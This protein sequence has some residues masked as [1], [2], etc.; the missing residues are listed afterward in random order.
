M[1]TQECICEW[2]NGDLRKVAV[3]KISGDKAHIIWNEKHKK[4]PNRCGCVIGMEDD[5]LISQLYW[6]KNEKV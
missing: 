2:P 4:I 3:T 6:K 5:V 1:K